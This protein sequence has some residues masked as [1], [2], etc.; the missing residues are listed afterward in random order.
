MKIKIYSLFKLP[1]EIQIS[2]DKKVDLYR[3]WGV[4]YKINKI[5]YYAD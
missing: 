2:S 3:W 5:T 4:G 1:I